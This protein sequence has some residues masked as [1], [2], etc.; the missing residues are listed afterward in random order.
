[1]S[2]EFAERLKT[3]R[4]VRNLT[5]SELAEKSGLPTSSIAQFET[6]ARKPSFDTL[7]KLSKALEVSTDY[8]LGTVDEPQT[9]VSFRDSEKIT[10]QDRELIQNIISMMAQKNQKNDK[11]S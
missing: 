1:M 11:T 10:A 6:K 4:A 8:L 9:S 2:D 5:Q 3:I 7:R